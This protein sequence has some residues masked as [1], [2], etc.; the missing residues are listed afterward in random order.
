MDI[1]ENSIQQET[2]EQHTHSYKDHIIPHFQPEEEAKADA[3]TQ[4][5]EK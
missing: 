3:V 1:T 4:E 5:A 2:P